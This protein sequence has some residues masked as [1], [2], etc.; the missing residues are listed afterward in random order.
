MPFPLKNLITLGICSSIPLFLFALSGIAQNHSSSFIAES[1][2]ANELFDRHFDEFVDRHP[3]FQTYI[4]IKKNY[5]EWNDTSEE[6]ALRELEI[7]RRNL[8]LYKDSINYDLLDD[9]T[10]ITYRLAVRQCEDQIRNFKYRHH[11]YP[12]SQRR[13]AHTDMPALLINMHKVSDAKDA[14]AYISRLSKFGAVFEQLIENL[15]TREAAGIVPPRFVFPR[16]IDSCNNLISGAPYINTGKDTALLTDFKEKIGS[17]EADNAG[18]ERLIQRAT[19]ALLEDVK[20]AY[21]SLIAFLED[22]HR[23]ANDEAGVWKFPDG[24]AYYNEALR[25]TTATQLTADE[26]HQIGLSEVDRIHE[27]MHGIM[28][29][30]NFQGSL[31]DFFEFMRTDERFYYP[32]TD[33]GKDAYLDKAVEVI[34]DMRSRLDSLFITK[35]MADMIVKRVETFREKSAG[36]AFYSPP[37]LDGSRPGIYY[38]NLYDTKNMPKYQLEALAYHEGIP[39][40]HMQL[41]I[42]LE[43]EGLPKIRKYNRPLSFVEGWGL[44]SEFLPLELG[45]YQDPYSNFGRLSKE[46]FRACRLVVDTGI[47][48]KRWTREQSIEYYQSNTPDSERDCIR[49]VE[50]HIVNASQATA[51]KV[52]MLKIIQLREK[53]KS[54]LGDAFDIKEFHE[55]VLTNGNISLDVL[56]ELIDEYIASK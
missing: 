49:M 18:R 20:P 55:A 48:A 5:D 32:N 4:G 39:G 23:R 6:A 37:A 25:L 34:D 17:I 22:Q 27:E 50:R 9:Q 15:K 11:N 3:E 53:A 52:G 43:L 46:L 41:A 2:K 47:H 12:V 42:N 30:V 36:T 51:Y 31:Q 28:N 40:H 56:E 19:K 26:I 10:K 24:E 38:A 33:E 14:E 8:Q 54:K 29:Q 13:G 44:Y 45:L 21:E 16:V 35:P 1:K 7:S